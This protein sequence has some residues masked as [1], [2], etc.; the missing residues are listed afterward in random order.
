MNDTVGKGWIGVDLDGTLA[1]YHG[2]VGPEYIGPPIPAM[3]DR[4]KLWLEEGRTVK[5]FTA[6]CSVPEQLA[7]VAEW[8]ERHGWRFT[9]L[10]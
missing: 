3:L 1:E 10:S 4:V 2:W 7:P 8:L 5:I 9:G 6:R